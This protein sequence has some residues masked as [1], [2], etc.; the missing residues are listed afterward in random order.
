MSELF[1]VS[2]WCKCQFLTINLAL[3]LFNNN[4]F[5]KPVLILLEKDKTM[6]KVKQNMF[7]CSLHKCIVLRMKLMTF[8][9]FHH[10]HT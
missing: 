4:L 2:T 10:P 7:N 8:D 9:Y 5:S 1:D 6:T 3:L